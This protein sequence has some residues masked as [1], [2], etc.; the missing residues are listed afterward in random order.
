MTSTT[1]TDITDTVLHDETHRMRVQ[2]RRLLG[3]LLSNRE[4]SEQRLAAAGIDDPI[5][6][7]TGCS[8]LDA[9]VDETREIIRSLDELDTR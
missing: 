5:K 7:L 9:A 6:M 4:A 8:S 3:D 1:T 2:A